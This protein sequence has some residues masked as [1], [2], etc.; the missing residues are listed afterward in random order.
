[1]L[2]LQSA[3]G[4]LTGLH[5]ADVGIKPLD[6]GINVGIN[7]THSEESAIKIIRQN[8][9]TTAAQLSRDLDVTLR[10]AERIIASLKKKAG[11]KRRGARK[12][13]EWYFEK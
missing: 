13:G 10:Q 6:V 3:N 4:C 7:F 2:N 8:S 9:K 5:R 12:N 1:M 11:L